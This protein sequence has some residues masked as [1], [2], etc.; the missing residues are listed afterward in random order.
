MRC[1]TKNLVPPLPLFLLPSLLQSTTISSLFAFCF[2]PHLLIHPATKGSY[3][4]KL[5]SHYTLLL[6]PHL[7][8][9]PTF[10]C[11][12]LHSTLLPSSVPPY[13]SS[14]PLIYHQTSGPATECSSLQL[15]PNLRIAEEATTKYNQYKQTSTTKQCDLQS[16]QR[17]RSHY[18][19]QV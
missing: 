12:S 18:A 1:R 4:F 17:R 5:L 13:T 11:T 9:R 16:Q 6:F 3:C 19:T 10:S 15:K 7:L 14:S 2:Q 8:S